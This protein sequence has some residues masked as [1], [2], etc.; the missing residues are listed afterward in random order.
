VPA[1]SAARLRAYEVAGASLALTLPGADPFIDAGDERPIRIYRGVVMDIWRLPH[2]AP[3]FQ[4]AG[5]VLDAASRTE[6]TAR[7]GTSTQLDRLELAAPGW[8]VT[9]NGAPAQIRTTQEIFQAVTLP[10][11]TSSIVFSYAPPF[12]G[13]AWAAA[14]I[15]VVA[16]VAWRLR[17]RIA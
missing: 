17:Q 16:A 8:Q 14:L 6:L 15:G 9:V 11:G 7:C 1:V 2:P 10:T 5:C 4:A 3:Y 12:V 13:W